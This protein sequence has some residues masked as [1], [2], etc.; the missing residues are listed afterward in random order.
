MTLHVM[1]KR[2]FRYH[3]MT[4][5]ITVTTT[6]FL[7]LCPNLNRWHCTIMWS[8]T[9]TTLSLC[10]L[11]LIFSQGLFSTFSIVRHV[12]VYVL[13][14]HIKY[15]KYL[16]ILIVCLRFFSF[17]DIRCCQLFPSTPM[18]GKSTIPG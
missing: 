17:A 18:A 7:Q 14:I 11:L 1:F 10:L 16:K 4:K 3:I 9:G 8:L 13:C 15:K 2:E 5:R 12:L 6:F